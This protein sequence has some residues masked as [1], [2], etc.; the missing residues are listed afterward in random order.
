[1]NRIKELRKQNNYTLQNVA[2]A[3][4]VSN[5]TVANY[6]NG[7]REPKLATWQNL[8][9]FFGV[10]VPY[11][12][13]VDNLLPQK[14]NFENFDNFKK[15]LEASGHTIE[16][17]SYR[18][19]ELFELQGIDNALNLGHDYYKYFSDTEIDD[20]LLSVENTYEMWVLLA[21]NNIKISKDER[22]KINA[23]Y[24]KYTILLHLL[25]DVSSSIFSQK[26]YD[27]F[28]TNTYLNWDDLNEI[29]DKTNNELKSSLKHLSIF[30]MTSS[31]LNEYNKKHHD[32]N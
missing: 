30:E 8:A 11:L 32:N 1:M 27:D 20:I 10:T 21:D 17:N 26:H 15:N 24:K 23:F 29:I 12:Q 28:D 4:G 16:E 3:I 22:D 6:E 9:D 25:R 19:F 13:G 31:E 5:G 2:D 14:N 7:K 18:A